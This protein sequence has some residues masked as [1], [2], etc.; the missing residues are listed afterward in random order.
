MVREGAS[1][2]VVF[3]GPSSEL[4]AI[5]GLPRRLVHEDARVALPRKDRFFEGALLAVSNAKLSRHPRNDTP[6]APIVEAFAVR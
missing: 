4:E 2:T 5:E 1:A 3:R 6:R